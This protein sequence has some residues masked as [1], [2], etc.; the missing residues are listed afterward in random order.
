MVHPQK[1]LDVAFLHDA[2]VII[3]HVEVSDR[4]GVGKL[5][6]MMYLGEPNILSIRSANFYDGRH[7]LGEL[8]FCIPHEDKTRDAVFSRDAPIDADPADSSVR[9]SNEFIRRA[10]IG[11][12]RGRKGDIPAIERE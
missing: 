5:V 10:D 12:P 2:D 8:A 7:E 1:P 11:L 9:G 3:T 6:Q 4:H